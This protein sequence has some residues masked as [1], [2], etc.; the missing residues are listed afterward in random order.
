MAAADR[1]PRFSPPTL[2]IGSLVLIWVAGWMVGYAAEDGS[3]ASERF[4]DSVEWGT[5]VFLAGASAATFAVMLVLGVRAIVRPY[6]GW[7]LATTQ[8]RRRYGYL[9]VALLF[10]A[11]LTAVMLGAEPWPAVADLPL[12]RPTWRTRGIIVA[13]YAAVVPWLALVWLAHAE[14]S[15]LKAST[16]DLP[17]DGLPTTDATQLSA[18]QQRAVEAFQDAITKLRRLWRLMTYCVTAAAVSIVIAIVTA[19]ALR[20]AFIAYAPK[21]ADEFPGV[22]GPAVRRP[23]R[24]PASGHRAPAHSDVAGAST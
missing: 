13:G 18:Q 16:E 4:V 5:W 24:G 1:T 10:M 11:G 2:T 6:P 17:P 7:G 22:G 20:V 19:G 15:R 23:V 9:I 8:A 14:C 3:P 21:R 12:Q